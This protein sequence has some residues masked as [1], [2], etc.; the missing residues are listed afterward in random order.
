[1]RGRERSTKSS[2]V[3]VFILIIIIIYINF[4]LLLFYFSADKSKRSFKVLF[5]DYGNTA[6]INKKMLYPLDDP[7]LLG[8][9]P[10]SYHCRLIDVTWTDDNDNWPE[11]VRLI[12][13]LNFHFSSFLLFFSQFAN[14]YM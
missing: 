6:T 5:V 9:P 4:S 8:I 2:S 3:D 1:M 7:A 14:A 10:M 12:F 13:S 11:D